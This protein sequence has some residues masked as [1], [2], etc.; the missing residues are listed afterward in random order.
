MTLYK[1]SSLKTLLNKTAALWQF[2]S[3]AMKQIQ[4][5]FVHVNRLGT[6]KHDYI[7]WQNNK[8]SAPWLPV[9][10][11][12]Q[13]IR[14]ELTNLEKA[15]LCTIC[16]RQYTD[17]LWVLAFP[18]PTNRLHVAVLDT[19][20]PYHS[21]NGLWGGIGA[22]HY[23][24]DMR[25]HEGWIRD[26]VTVTGKWISQMRLERERAL[27]TRAERE[28]VCECVCVCVWERERESVW[29]CP[30]FPPLTVYYVCESFQTTVTLWWIWE[31]FLIFDRQPLCT[32]GNGER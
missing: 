32:T 24:T 13:P 16:I 2:S 11:W 5:I 15:I 3:N 26:W 9:I 30:T 1:T 10:V 17:D 8:T 29:T 27:R 6:Y 19:V 23:G 28:S 18:F 4:Q 14:L 20:H 12:S 25:N 22:W 21:S 31:D 7:S